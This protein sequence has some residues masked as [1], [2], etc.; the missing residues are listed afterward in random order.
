M[1]RKRNLLRLLRNR[2]VSATVIAALAVLTGVAATIIVLARD[3]DER[4]AANPIAT[5]GP[6]GNGSLLATPTATSTGPAAAST[7]QPTAT[8]TPNPAL[9]D[10]TRLLREGQFAEAAASFQAVADRAN[11]SGERAEALLGA[12]LARNE[13]GD[14]DGATDAARAA[15]AAAPGGSAVARRAAFVL[16]QRLNEAEKWPE[17]ASVLKPFAFADATDAMQPYVLNEYATAAVKAGQRAE[18]RAAWQR[19]AASNAPGDLVVGA[20]RGLGDAEG[21]PAA[22]A[23]W[24]ARALAVREDGAV[25]YQLA[26]AKKAAG[27]SAAWANELRRI[28]DLTPASRFALVVVAELRAAGEPVN[29]GDEGL[30][31]YRAGRP[32]D[33]RRVLQAAIAE[34]GLAPQ[35][36][37]FRNFFLGAA[38]ED[39]GDA[40]GAVAAYDRSAAADA[41]YRHRASYWAARV[42]ESAGD[43][44]GASQRYVALVTAGPAGEFT[45]EA[46]FRAGYVLLA[47]GDPAGAV[48]AWDGLAI[49]A[50][51][52]VLYWKGRALAASGAP[53]ASDAYAAAVRADPLSFYGVEA[54]RVLGQVAAL[55]VRYVAMKAP[56]ATDWAALESWL[57]GVVPGAL[58]TAPRT[59]ANE[60]VSV[61]LSGEAESAIIDAARG[62]D[63][64]A[65]LALAKE[66]S[67]AR[68]PSVAAQLA[69]RLRS[70]AGATW[71]SAPVDLLRL[72]YPLDYFTVVDA[73]ARLNNLDPLFLA[74]LI[75]QE[76][77]WDAA[78]GSPA[79]AL[80]LTQVIP[81]TGSAIA[82]SLGI[83][84]AAEDLFRPAV[85]IRFGA[86]Y[87]AGQLRRSGNAYLALAAYN[88]GPGNADR[89]A[90]RGRL[91]AAPDLVESID[92]PETK[93][94]VELV[95]DHYA[96]YLAAYR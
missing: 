17:A 20:L 75:R 45:Q 19:I 86:N 40:A 62:A 79:G 59:A 9:E 34:P 32:V 88:A 12:S 5:A 71:Q 65:T 53:G 77:Y 70:Q 64:W 69:V 52:R 36:V 49:A 23:A 66:A 31:Y 38:L 57:A 78:A 22:R 1:E 39:L 41:S 89:W 8:P 67:E 68:L 46:A 94:Y 29:A 3:G 42:T 14:A 73:Q 58:S 56:A 48:A 35:A 91:L 16:A 63:A 30:A 76:S 85:S 44:R 7:P 74:A 21:D 81:E 60:L 80:G 13:A 72:A 10:P 11:A 61:G 54:A 25:R 96:H 87:L 37:A 28:M 50:D 6:G 15:L 93:G 2:R 43:A 82:Q 4:A 95:M 83:D 90:A 33:A 84:F 55:D 92:I 51:A 27:D 26:Q 24:L 18:A 47:S